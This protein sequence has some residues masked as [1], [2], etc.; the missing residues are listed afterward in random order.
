MQFDHR[1]GKY[2]FPSAL[3][4]EPLPH[5][6]YPL[7]FLTLVRRKALH[8]QMPSEQQ[9][10]PPQ[11]WIAADSPVWANLDVKKD[12]YLVSPV[13]R[14]KVSL[15]SLP[16]LHPEVVLYRRGDWMCQGG[17]AN[18]LIESKQ[19]DMGPGAAYYSQCVNLEN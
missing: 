12:V 6:E 5:A 7:R 10:Q 3:H 14:L 17:G 8:S 11:A 13:G 4:A 19:T 15:K 1:D 16:G 2:R 9:K 18:Q